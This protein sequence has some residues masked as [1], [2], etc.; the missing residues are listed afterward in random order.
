MLLFSKKFGSEDPFKDALRAGSRMVENDVLAFCPHIGI[1][2]GN[3][4]AGYV[5]T[6]VKYNASLFGTPVNLA[7]RCATVKPVEGSHSSITF[8]AS[9]WGDKD[10]K[11]LIPARKEKN[12]DGKLI[13]EPY[14]WQINNP[15]IVEIKNMGKIQIREL[16]RQAIWMP[17]QS[18]EE[19]AKEIFQLILKG[20]QYRSAAH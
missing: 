11:T 5:G 12:S 8:P 17:Q 18:A 7:A 9:E 15:R 13:E 6:P 4:T 1:A 16:E 20:G 10:I 3:V 2:S 14:S 19:R